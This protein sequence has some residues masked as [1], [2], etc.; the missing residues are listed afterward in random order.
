VTQKA[1]NWRGIALSVAGN[2]FV[3]GLRCIYGS[4]VI[5]RVAD[6]WPN[7]LIGVSGRVRNT[8]GRAH[9]RPSMPQINAQ[10]QIE[11]E[12]PDETT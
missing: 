7:H 12:F 9:L 3:T 6:E 8:S 5:D 2:G 4:K 10:Q 11:F 1:D